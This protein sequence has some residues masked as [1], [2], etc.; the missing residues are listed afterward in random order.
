MTDTLTNAAPP[1]DPEM[2]KIWDAYREV[3]KP[4]EITSGIDLFFGGGQF[5]HSGAFAAG[6]SVKIR[7]DLSDDLFK[8][9][10]VDRIPEVLS[11]EVWRTDSSMGSALS[12]FGIIYNVDRLND[13]GIAKPPAQW[14]DLADYKYFRQVG[15]ADPTKSGSIAKA[16]EMIVHQKMHEAA[17]EFI[18]SYRSRLTREGDYR[19]Q[20]M[21]VNA[22]IAANENRIEAFIKSRAKAYQRG[23]VPDDLKDYQA[24][25]EKGFL[26]GLHL[27][28]AIGANARYFTDSAS[29]V[30]IDVS[31]GDAS[32]GMAI[33]FYGRFQAQASR[34][35]GGVE[36]MKYVTPIGGTSVSCDPISLLRGAGG[37]AKADQQQETR[38][39]ALRFIQFVLS[40]EGQRLWAYSPGVKDDAGNLIGPEKYALRRLPIARNFY[41]ATQPSL[42]DEAAA[43]AK[44]FADDLTDP[45][46]DP[47]RVAEQFTY[48]PRWTGDHFLILRDIVRAMCIDSSDE[49]KEAWQRIHTTLDYA[50]LDPPLGPMPVVFLA[51]KA[52]PGATVRGPN[53]SVMLDWRTAPDIRRKYDSLE[54]MRAWTEKFREQ[55]HDIAT[56]KLQGTAKGYLGMSTGETE[57]VRVPF[58]VAATP[59]SRTR[60]SRELLERDASD[61]T[62]RVER[63]AGV[64]ATQDVAWH[65][66]L[67]LIGGDE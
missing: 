23:D 25:L 8:R 59:A 57:L 45:T 56:G 36:R 39:V 51:P 61:S 17:A 18:R 12:T 22:E 9:D 20:T 66:T 14:D 11:G 31:M 27:I 15:L 5:D 4:S 49:L 44:H 54:Y 33:D 48:Y 47:Y 29:K 46:V 41:P 32:V 42:R 19:P 67:T 24:A 50:P 53:V 26:D 64:A 37:H 63:D 13:L 65:N 40:D 58:P 35:P 28:Q 55:Y 34:G 62:L 52:A 7:K 10:G 2:R 43:H 6:F 21:D 38:E 16:F 60:R 1:T 30:P 3:D